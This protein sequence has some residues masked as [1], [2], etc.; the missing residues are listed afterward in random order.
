VQGQAFEGRP[1]KGQAKHAGILTHFQTKVKRKTGILDR[2]TG[3]IT[4][5]NTKT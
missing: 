2:I 1:L 4:M 3:F 5:K